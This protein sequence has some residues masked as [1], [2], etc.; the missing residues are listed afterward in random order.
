MTNVGAAGGG[1]PGRPGIWQTGDMRSAGDWG[2]RWSG[3]RATFRF[4]ATDPFFPPSPKKRGPKVPRSLK[5]ITFRPFWFFGAETGS[6]EL[7]FPRFLRFSECSP[8]I[9]FVPETSTGEFR[10]LPPAL[11]S[12]L[13]NGFLPRLFSSFSLRHLFSF[14]FFMK[15]SSLVVCNLSPIC[16]LPDLS[17]SQPPHLPETGA[18]EPAV[19]GGSRKRRKFP[20]GSLRRKEDSGGTFAGT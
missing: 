15:S 6:Q 11:T 8:G 14:L 10:R 17:N 1:I 20:G 3:V 7:H 13:C 16:P 19:F 2:T 5:A 12:V 4:T 9:F 18:A